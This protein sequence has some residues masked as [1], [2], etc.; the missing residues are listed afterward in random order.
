MHIP[1]FPVVPS[2]IARLPE[3][4]YN[5][6]WS[7]HPEALA[8][9]RALDPELWAEVTHNP[10]Q[11]LQRVSPEKLAAVV[12]DQAYL[13]QYDQVL[14]DFDAYMQVKDTW[15]HRTYP[16]LKSKIQNPLVVYFSAEFGL[17]ECMPIYSGGLGVLSG[18]HCKEASDLGLPFVGV[19]FL[20]PQGY[21]TQHITPDGVQEAAYGKLDLGNLPAVPATGPDGK[22]VV[23]KVELPGRDVY[24]KVWHIQVG[25]VPL[26]LMDT[27]VDPN[28]PRDR[29]L[30]ARL[31]GGDQ[32]MRIAQEIILGIGGVRAVRALGLQPAV[33]HLNEGHAAFLGLERIRELMQ[34]QGLTFAEA[35]QAVSVNA[36]FTTHTPV[37]AGNDEFPLWLIDK[38]FSL[39][40]DSLGLSREEFID[41]ARQSRPWGPTFSMTMLALRLAAQY[42]GVSK[43]HG[44]VSR[45]MWH[46]LWPDVP[47]DEVPITSVTNGVHTRTWL[48]PE[49]GRLYDQ[50]LD[51]DWEACLDNPGTWNGIDAIPDEVLWNVK[52][53]LKYKLIDYVRERLRRDWSRGVLQIEQVIAAGALLDPDALTIGFARRFATYKRATLL[54]R[55]VARLLRLLNQ[56]GRPV[57]VIFAGK[58]HPADEPGKSFIRQI[59]RAAREQAF[60][61][62]IVF[63]ED[64]DIEMA[65]HL[66]AG[67]DVWLNN[68]RR[69]LEA[70]G[71]SG[72]KA[73]LNGIPNVSILDGWWREGYNGENGWAIG[74]EQEWADKEAQDAADAQALYAILENEVIPLYYTRDATGIPHGWLAKVRQAIKTIAPAFSTRRMVKEY[75][76]RMYVPAAN[77]GQEL[78]VRMD[79]AAHS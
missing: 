40:W 53:Q 11:L 35:R 50:Y 16:N 37:A 79:R 63:L 47:V 26:Y 22:P 15:F 73:S 17:H 2:R 1:S 29:E 74:D 4:A 28:A 43:L 19:G 8:L 24:A 39:Y 55:D 52:R 6:W 9:F 14:A 68:P 66:V 25:R 59:Y 23:I 42:N 31:Y 33:W 71:T 56:P 48:A 62:R 38:Y 13:A 45:Q 77:Q 67:V 46:N 72:Q 49:L 3:L 58:A 54:F 21:F 5:L 75:V 44:H 12:Q 18:D 61:G 57:Q 27:D 32:E 76:E 65:R 34:D 20:Y 69:P 51:S 7:W 10:I 64:Y 70:S 41:L 78:A 30:S 60:A 36:V